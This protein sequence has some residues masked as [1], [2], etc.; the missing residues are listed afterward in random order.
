MPDVVEIR[1][2]GVGGAPPAG[3]LRIAELRHVGGD[4]TARFLRRSVPPPEPPAREAFHW[5]NMTSGSVTK[6][7]WLLLA[8]FG[9]LNLARYTLPMAVRVPGKRETEVRRRVRQTA[10][11]V[12]RLL[13]LVLTLLL[14]AAVAFVA[15]DLVAWQC[16]GSTLCTSGNSWVPF[17]GKQPTSWSW[18]LPLGVA[19]PAALIWLLVRFGRQVYVYPPPTATKPEEWPDGVGA[20]AQKPFW[21]SSPRAP[22]LRVFHTTAAVAVLAM[23][24]AYASV[25]PV[26][27][28]RTAEGW[29]DDALWALFGFAAAV[30]LLCVALTAAGYHPRGEKLVYDRTGRDAIRIPVPCHMLRW[31]MWVALLA[32]VV[33][34]VFFGPHTTSQGTGSPPVN[35]AGFAWAFNA[36]YA[37]CAVLL[38]AL[39]VTTLFLHGVI[40][41]AGLAKEQRPMWGGLACPVLASLAVLLATGFTAG[42]AIQTARLLGRL[43]QP[44]E[45]PSGGGALLVLPTVFHVTAL[46]WALVPAVAVV[47]GICLWVFRPGPVPDLK[48]RIRSDYPQTTEEDFPDRTVARLAKAWR[49][50]ALKYRLPTVLVVVALTGFA[51]ALLQ[52]CFAGEALVLG[53]DRGF[54]R[55]QDA[56]YNRVWLGVKFF[57]LADDIGAWV[58]TGLA[59]GLVFLGVRAFRSLQWRRAVGV[60]WDLLA[61]WPRLA[62]PIV[63][64]PYGGRAVLALTR[65]IQDKTAEG[66]TVVLSGHSQ[67]SLI[68][69]AAVLQAAHAPQPADPPQPADA[70]QPVDR[71]ALLTHGSQ[72]T[73]AYA[74][75]FPAYVGHPLLRDVYTRLNGRWRN[76]HRW[77]DYLGGPVL[78]RPAEGH[79]RPSLG[80]WETI[81]RAVVTPDPGGDGDFWCRRIGPEIQL[82]DPHRIV[83]R[84]D[85]PEAPLLKHSA[86]YAD[87]AYDHVLQELID[88]VPGRQPSA[89]APARPSAATRLGTAVARRL[90]AGR[91]PPGR[92]P[93]GGFRG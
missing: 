44:E 93:G 31:S 10:D 58:L 63:P 34:A 53:E 92:R 3:V 64:P 12:L 11:A 22:M 18:R 81:D 9:I 33:L 21:S 60:L 43:V 41:T 85:K 78:A 20:L 89:A 32:V 23:L 59:A 45:A 35:L 72:L 25:E 8:P 74:R 26:A 88:S 62:H 56:L 55:I 71:L 2:H 46:L 14:T 87:P 36:L 83:A 91:R 69:V 38:L 27:G 80:D 70:P 15:I 17:S 28:L 77:S 73:W 40:P 61:F 66:G 49:Q 19:A 51:C 30:G 7:L 5:A 68:C 54:N 52:G 79:V 39:L 6:A 86:Y 29:E 13:G 90:R 76:L 16:G 75:L 57:G 67:G 84:D 65:R 4:D 82:R 47:L 1:V 48:G 24:V 37:A 42:F 50:A